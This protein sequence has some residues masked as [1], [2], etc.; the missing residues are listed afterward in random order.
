MERALHITKQSQLRYYNKKYNRLYFGIEFC[1]NLIPSVSQLEESLLF[2]KNNKIAFTLVTPFVTEEGLSRL[3]KIFK[4]L[5][6]VMK[7][8]E[9]VV[10]DWGVLE[11]LCHDYP[12]F[13]LSLGR[14]L[15]RQNRD[16]AIKQI[17]KK[18]I[19]KW[20]KTKDGKIKI[21]VQELPSQCYHTGIRSSYLNVY[22]VQQFLSKLGVQRIELNNTLQGINFDQL[23]LKASLYTPFVNISTTR[24]CPMETKQQKMHRIQ[25][26]RKECQEH[27]YVLRKRG[28][29]KEI[30]KRGTTIFYKNPVHLRKIM[31]NA[32]DRIVFQP[33]LPL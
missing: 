23:S 20:I 18:H 26:C 16:P 13:S 19:P 22:S 9:V 33:E 4:L 30:Y 32:V 21:F 29:P 8:C 14:L 3:D 6:S 25:S 24:F 10:N 2:V 7:G 11:L 1:Q 12:S 15:T 27:Y 17:F 5:D 28:A 31:C